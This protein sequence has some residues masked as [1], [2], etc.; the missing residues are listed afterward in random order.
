MVPPQHLFYFSRR[1]LTRLLEN[2][3]FRVVSCVRPWKLIPLGLVA[4]LVG[5]W[6]NFRLRRLEALGS[7]GI[8]VNLFDTIRLVARKE[9]PHSQPR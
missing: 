1:T 6:L 9:G 3:G 5:I 7:L 4:Y 8:P 2:K